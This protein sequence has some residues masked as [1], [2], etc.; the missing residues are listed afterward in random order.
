[1]RIRMFLAMPFV[2]LAVA[3]ST[4]GMFLLIFSDYLAG[5]SYE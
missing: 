2:L 5:N 1:M 3:F 4:V